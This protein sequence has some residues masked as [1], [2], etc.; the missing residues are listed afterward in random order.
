[1]NKL[2]APSTETAEQIVTETANELDQL[3]RQKHTMREVELLLMRMNNKLGFTRTALAEPAPKRQLSE[4]E[5]EDSYNAAVY[6]EPVG[7]EEAPS[8]AARIDRRERKTREELAD[9]I[10]ELKRR[11]YVLDRPVVTGIDLASEVW[12]D[13]E[14]YRWLR[15]NM[16]RDAGRIPYVQMDDDDP[17][18]KG[19]RITIHID[20]PEE[21]DAAIDAARTSS[22]D[23]REKS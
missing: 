15:E 22:Q 12:R 16:D 23:G 7:P 13:A 14:R 1:M 3:F 10:E 18:F 8:E 21:L 2:V 5:L 6:G 17:V 19:Q 9:E 4:K 20:T 11:L